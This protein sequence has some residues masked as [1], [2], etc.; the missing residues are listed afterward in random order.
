MPSWHEHTVAVIMTV[1][2]DPVGCATTLSSLT[3]Q[4]RTPDEIIVVDGGSTEDTLRLIGQ[5][6]SSLPQLRLIQ[7]PGSNIAHGRNVAV[8][9]AKSEIII[10][11]DSG[12]RADPGWVEN[13]LKPFQQ[14]AKVEFVAGFYKVDA[15]SL[16]EQVVGLATMRGQLDPVCPESFNPSARSMA[17]TKALWTRAG[18]W[19]EW[20]HYSEDTLFDHKIR[21]MNVGWRYAGDAIVHWRPRRTL[22]AIARQFYHYATGRGHTRIDAGSYLY[23][24]RNA[25]LIS[26]GLASSIV[27]RWALL[28]LIAITL[29]FYVWRFHHKCLRIARHTKQWV[30]YPLCMCIMWAIVAANIVGFTVGTVQRWRDRQRFQV[31]MEAYFAG[32]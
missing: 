32:V 4:T 11:T 1:K 29:Y 9:A 3:A 10:S 20:I 8:R 5:Y 15:Y 7:S 31:R 24:L 30:A 2:N 13:L 17:L 22:P 16:V 21:K 12:C 18:G 26:L 6:N 19:P 27:T 28:P 25:A 23:D 14:D